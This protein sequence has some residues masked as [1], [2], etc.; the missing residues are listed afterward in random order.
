MSAFAQLELAPQAPAP[1]YVGAPYAEQFSA[2]GGIPFYRWTL[3]SGALP[4]GLELDSHDGVV[5]GTPTASGRYTFTLGVEAYGG[6]R[7][8]RAYDLTVE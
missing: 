1:A 3:A 2:A 7:V 4:D 5:Y 8:T 6:E